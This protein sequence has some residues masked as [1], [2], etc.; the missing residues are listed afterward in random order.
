MS[1]LC[2]QHLDIVIHNRHLVKA[3]HVNFS[4]GE[5]WGLM[6]RNG[7][8]KTMLLHTLAGLRAPSHGAVLL[9]D[10]DL[11][12]YSIK[13]RARHIGVLFQSD[14]SSFPNTVLD[15]ALSGRYPHQTC[16]Q[17]HSVQD[18]GMVNT[19]L[20]QMGLD[21]LRQ[22]DVD[23]LSGGERQKLRLAA[24]L[25]QDPDVYLLDEP[26]NHLDIAERVRLLSLLRAQAKQHNKLVVMVCHEPSLVRDFCDHVLV[27]DSG[28]VR[29]FDDCAKGIACLL[30]I[31]EISR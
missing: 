12:H 4:G 13:Q 9:K 15:V 25:T 18:K 29:I 14:E 1:L 22:R 5:V 27:L 11:S 2:S 24:L 17:G 10:V 8:G 23:T 21:D 28:H 3:S 6:G 31:C 26:T 19:V 7:V 16:W 20:N 30:D